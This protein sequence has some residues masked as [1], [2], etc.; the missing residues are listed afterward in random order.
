MH[1]G[2]SLINITLLQ[3]AMTEV[4]TVLVGGGM[5]NAAGIMLI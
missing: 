3:H 5:V 2:I 4:S 1:T